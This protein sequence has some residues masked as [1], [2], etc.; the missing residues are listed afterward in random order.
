MKR[1]RIEFGFFLSLCRQR[2]TAEIIGEAAWR[3]DIEEF[4]S[5]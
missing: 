3:D 1:L 5:G 2:K 4:N